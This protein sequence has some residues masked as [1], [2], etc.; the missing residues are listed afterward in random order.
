[1]ILEKNVF[2][3]IDFE[4]KNS[5]LEEVYK[6]MLENGCNEEYVKSIPDREKEASFNIGCLIAIPHGTYEAS[7]KI[8]LS[9]IFVWHLKKPL[10]W[11]D[12][13][14]KLIIALCLNN[15]DQLNILQN[16]AI[17]AMDEEIFE[18][19][20]QNPTKKDILNLFEEQL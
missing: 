3:N 11:D 9:Q 8:T 10:K 13:E 18:D 19:T 17:K 7:Q 5:A 2:L 12:S 6:V 1:M 15:D 20:L 16:I 14:V 4:D